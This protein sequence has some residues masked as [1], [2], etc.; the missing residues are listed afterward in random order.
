[1]FMKNLP[2]IINKV[3][4]ALLISILPLIAGCSKDIATDVFIKA[5]ETDIVLEYTGLNHEGQP[6]SFELGSNETWKVVSLPAWLQLNRKEAE[7]GRSQI[8]VR[9]EEN[10]TGE[11][12]TGFIELET[13]SGKPEQI[14]VLQKHLEATLTLSTY[15]I[16]ANLLGT[17][18][19]G[20]P[21]SVTLTSNYPWTITMPENSQWLSLD[22]QA[23]EAGTTTIG[24]EFDPNNT[25]ST[26]EVSLTCTAGKIQRVLVV[27]QEAK[28]FQLNNKQIFLNSTGTLNSDGHAATIAITALESWEVTDKPQW[29]Q[30]SPVTGQ[31]GHTTMAFTANSSEEPREGRVVLRS[32]HLSTDTISVVQLGSPQLT[33]DNK[34]VGH[35]YFSESFDWAS[36]I[37][38]QNPDICQDQVGSINGSKGK[39]IPIYSNATVKALFDNTLED[40]N[41][42]GKCIYVADG[43]LKLGKN[44]NQTGVTTKHALDIA[45]GNRADVEISFDIAK[46]GT[47]RMTVTVEIQGDGQ[48]EDG[49]TPLMSKPFVPIDNKATDQ[50]WQWKHHQSVRV[51]G[52]TARTRFT[53]RATQFPST[54]GYYRWFLD[55]IKI[56]RITTN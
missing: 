11:D 35:I 42:T 6:A 32:T 52:V 23:G 5:T 8:F 14:A 18:A 38:A 2:V 17:S 29:L 48:I 30:C 56:T 55:N 37:A 34:P 26:R 22:R 39:T 27:K 41:P 44:N 47:D 1:M 9:A 43:Y 24:L 51:K 31:L 12:R 4:H 3:L 54:S 13:L 40:A 20:Q 46:N 16:V 7:R 33:P 50:P 25:G 21:L 49:E 15:E 53:I 19:N 45:E 36:T 28:A 10:R